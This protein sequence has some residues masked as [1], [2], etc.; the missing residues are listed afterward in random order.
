MDCFD[1]L[2]QK[3][4]LPADPKMVQLKASLAQAE[5]P[6]VTPAPL[7]QLRNDV[8]MSI[9]QAANRRITGAQDLTWALINNPAFLFN[10]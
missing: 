9:Q 5:R 4:P 1:W 10:H 2:Q 7:V 6:I 8:A 3:R